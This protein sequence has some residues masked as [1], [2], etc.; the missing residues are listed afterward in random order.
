[1]CV[2]VG[3]VGWLCLA[4]VLF[5][6]RFFCWFVFT[7]LLN[8][9][10]ANY[11]SLILSRFLSYFLALFQ[12]TKAWDAEVI[13]LDDINALNHRKE[14]MDAENPALL[15]RNDAMNDEIASLWEK[16]RVRSD[17]FSL[18]FFSFVYIFE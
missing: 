6:L 4:Y 2:G 16:V 13:D 10:L 14:E 15:K 12:I 5:V 9:F 1:M 11:F 17:I 18:I 7:L 3:F 8:I